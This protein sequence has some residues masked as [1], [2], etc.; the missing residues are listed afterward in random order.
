M[1][2]L[3]ITYKSYSCYFLFSFQYQWLVHATTSCFVLNRLVLTID[4]SYDCFFLVDLL[5]IS[6]NWT[7]RK[8][9]CFQYQWHVT[10]LHDDT[11]SLQD[12]DVKTENA[13]ILPIMTSSNERNAKHAVKKNL[14]GIRMYSL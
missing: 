5:H 6:N 8:R 4:T 11:D 1:P 2:L 13:C 12:R 10:V 9:S 14:D 3:I 7:K